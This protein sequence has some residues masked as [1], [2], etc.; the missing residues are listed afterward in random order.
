MGKPKPHK[1]RKPPSAGSSSAS[2]ELSPLAGACAIAAV[3]LAI[4]AGATY[5]Y[6]P[7]GT[8]AAVGRVVDKAV[9]GELKMSDLGK[10]ASVSDH[11]LLQQ[12]RAPRS[13]QH[14]SFAERCRDGYG[15]QQRASVE[16]CTSDEKL[17]E[18]CCRSCHDLTC[19]DLDESCET[20][21]LQGECIDNPTFMKERCCW[22][23]SP[24][25]DDRCSIDPSKRPDVHKGDIE[26]TFTRILEQYPQYSPTVHSRDPWVVSFDNLLDDDECAGIIEAVGGKRGECE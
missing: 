24:D 10:T 14:L 11:E 6:S 1:P 12:G 20:W 15:C 16:A 9:R 17:R 23:C 13:K 18:S 26:K 3:G 25:P 19:I 5:V 7:P 8:Q 2:G 21:A 22:S 4:V